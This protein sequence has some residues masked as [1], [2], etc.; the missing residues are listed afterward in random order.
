MW[1][2]HLSHNAPLF[3]HQDAEKR[4][5]LHAA[6]FLGDGEITELLILSGKTSFLQISA[7]FVVVFYW[8]N[9]DVEL[10]DI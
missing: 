4:T 1:E 2:G 3:L 6:A 7:V 9:V 8:M 10:Y 5:P